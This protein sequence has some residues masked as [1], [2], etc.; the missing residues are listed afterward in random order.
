MKKRPWD[1]EKYANRTPLSTVVD[2][3]VKLIRPP[4]GSQHWKEGLLLVV[5]AETE[6]LLATTYPNFK[7]PKTRWDLR[8]DC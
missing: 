5:D 2:R 3:A 1:P 7:D 6:E 8:P 4:M